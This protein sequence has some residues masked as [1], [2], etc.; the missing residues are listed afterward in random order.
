LR[1][2]RSTIEAKGL[3]TLLGSTS[4]PPLPVK[5]VKPGV[6]PQNI[7]DKIVTHSKETVTLGEALKFH[8]AGMFHTSPSREEIV[9]RCGR[10]ILEYAKKFKDFDALD[11]WKAYRASGIKTR[12]KPLGSA[13]NHMKWYLGQFVPWAVSKGYLPDTAKDSLEKIKQVR[14]NPRRIRIPSIETIEEFL[15]MV[16]SEDPDG[17]EFLRFL[18][19]CGLRITAARSLRRRDIDF[20]RMTM[21]VTMKGGREI[22]LPLT[23]EALAILISRRDKEMPWSFD[24]AAIERLNKRMK[25]F[26]KGFDIDLTYFHAWRHYFASRC[27]LHGLTV[28]EVAELL[29]HSDKGEVALRTYGHICK[30]HLKNAVAGL[31]LTTRNL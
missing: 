12:G 22:V 1:E 29:G 9:D 30:E 14:V 24:D 3:D 18:A 2:A 20:E 23:Q 6:P 19:S 13:C 10:K 7:S 15:A 21:L 11:V 17:A 26:A 27:L 28:Q 16:S 4:A 8:A 25:K 5:A 31:R